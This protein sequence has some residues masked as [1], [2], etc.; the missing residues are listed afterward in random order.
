MWLPLRKL[1]ESWKDKRDFKESVACG[2]GSDFSVVFYFLMHM[3]MNKTRSYVFVLLGILMAGGLVVCGLLHYK[4]VGALPQVLSG[5][6]EF[7][8]TGVSQETPIPISSLKKSC[9]T[10]EKK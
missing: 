4:D 3:K 9:T 7:S 2:V 5:D 6:V 1:L 8:V 10:Q